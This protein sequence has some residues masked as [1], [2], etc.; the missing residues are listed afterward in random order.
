MDEPK[1]SAEEAIPLLPSDVPV[2]MPDLPPTLLINTP[3][4]YKA[5]GDETR[6]KIMVIIKQQPATAKQ[7]ADR[8]GIAPGTAGHH[9]Q[10]LEAAGLAKVA[11]RRLVR[12]IVAKYYTRT[13][14]LLLFD[15][16]EEHEEQSGYAVHHLDMLAEA[17]REMQETRETHPNEDRVLAVGNPHTRLSKERA[18]EFAKRLHA[19]VDEFATEPPASEGLVYGMST[20]MYIAPDYMQVQDEPPATEEA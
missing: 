18:L 16:P 12:G 4:Q 3:Q 14:K 10:T 15:R 5:L 9:L 19:L 8:L 20:A 11:A 13:A 17:Q 1:H 2:T 6:N 7:I